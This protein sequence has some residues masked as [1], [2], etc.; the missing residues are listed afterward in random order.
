MLF[1]AAKSCPIPLVV[2]LISVFYALKD[3]SRRYIWM[4][5]VAYLALMKYLILYS[6][7]WFNRAAETDFTYYY[8]LFFVML[9]MFVRVT[10]YVL[11]YNDAMEM[12]QNEA[13]KNNVNPKHFTLVNYL[14]Y[15]FYTPVIVHGPP[16]LFERYATVLDQKRSQNIVKRFESFSTLLLRFSL[17]GFCIEFG[18]YLFFTTFVAERSQVSRTFSGFGFG[19]VFDA[20]NS[21]ERGFSLF[22][23]IVSVLGNG[24]SMGSVW[25][26]H[27][28]GHVLQSDEHAHVLN[29]TGHRQIRT[30]GC[31]EGSDVHLRHQLIPASLAQL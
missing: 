25:I 28:I 4:V 21:L 15:V 19:F 16:L 22:R 3:C 26:R 20:I 17:W 23:F 9:W 8:E 13:N 24:R 11:E 12:S 29:C 5:A 1:I 2:L 7:M 27:R 10:S 31:S 6:I 14:G 30:N 18:R